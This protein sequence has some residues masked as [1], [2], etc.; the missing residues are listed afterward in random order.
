MRTPSGCLFGLFGGLLIASWMGVLM[1]GPGRGGSSFSGVMGAEVDGDIRLFLAQCFLSAFCLLTSIS[2]FNAK[3]LYL[4]KGE[5][6]ALLS[7]PISVSD[8]VRYRLLVDAGKTA[9]SS[10][11]FVALFWG[12]L[13]KPSYGVFG[14]LLALFTI[15][16]ISRT[17]SL[18]LGNTNRWLGRFFHGRTLGRVG[19]FVGALAWGVMIF[20]MVKSDLSVFVGELGLSDQLQRLMTD[21]LVALILTPA[22]PFA[23][24]VMAES[25]GDFLLWLAVDIGILVVAFELCARSAGEIREAS[26]ATSEALAKR[27]GAMRK[28]HSGVSAL[29]RVRKAGLRVSRVP[30]LFGRGRAGTIAWAQAV[31]IT[32]FSLGTFLLSLF[33]VGFFVMITVQEE[34][35]G[36]IAKG[37]AQ[38]EVVF[39]ALII[40]VMGTMYL[41]ASMRFDFR[42]SL[43]RM[44]CIKSWPVSANRLFFAM[45]LPQALLM[46]L[47]VFIGVFARAAFT[48]V[49]HPV[50]L[51]LSALIPVFIYAWISLDNAVFLFFPVRFIP[52]QDGAMHHMGRS[53][54]LL[55]LRVI[56]FIVAGVILAGVLF[57]LGLLSR[58]LGLGEGVVERLGPWVLLIGIVGAGVAFNLIGGIGLRR[59]DISRSV[60]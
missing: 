40:V 24:L 54:L 15:T 31:G 43:S 45:V 14:L 6:Q 38:R 52:G 35:A 53:I 11:V 49:F 41:G 8:L 13:P 18:A 22:R 57:S 9:V 10:I 27:V 17:F 26:M 28:G 34:L 55:F 58:A 36:D 33:V 20:L 47:V 2:A 60:N 25:A 16:V 48:G 23:E 37:S 42:T 46:T 3:G 7:A 5:V 4:P 56:L 21:P 50:L 19:F 59:Y 39:S 51:E 12:R 29:G 30:R 32:R 44:E 1:F